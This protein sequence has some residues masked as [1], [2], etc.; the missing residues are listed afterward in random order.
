[1]QNLGHHVDAAMDFQ[2]GS[3]F[4]YPL[5]GYAYQF[6]GPRQLGISGGYTHSF[7]EKY[8]ARFYFRISNALNQDYFEDGFQTPRRWA[9]GG[10]HLTF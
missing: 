1:M 6:N 10:I 8:S 5:Y 4:L 2:G 3:N 7:G 9:V